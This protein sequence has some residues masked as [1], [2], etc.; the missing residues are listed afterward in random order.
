MGVLEQL[1]EEQKK[2]AVQIG[3]VYRTPQPAIS[4]VLRAPIGM[5]AARPME[6]FGTPAGEKIESALSGIGITPER[7]SKLGYQ[8]GI[9]DDAEIG[10]IPAASA[11]PGRSPD[12]IMEL[13]RKAREIEAG[14]QGYV[15]GG[16]EMPTP[17]TPTPE[18]PSGPLPG[19]RAE[20]TKPGEEPAPDGMSPDTRAMLL[21]L[22]SGLTSAGRRMADVPTLADI[23]YGAGTQRAFTP[24]TQLSG[25][26]ERIETEQ[27][28]KVE[29]EEAK[30]KALEEGKVSP[31]V[32]LAKRYATAM[33]VDPESI[34]TEQQANSFLETAGAGEKIK[35][36]EA[37]RGA[38]EG[39][40]EA[41]AAEAKRA[42]IDMEAVAAGD[43]SK[44][45]QDDKD[46]IT[47][48]KQAWRTLPATKNYKESYA[49]AKQVGALLDAD[50][51]TASRAAIIAIVKA[52][53]ETGRLSD[54]DIK[55]FQNRMGIKGWT[56]RIENTLISDLNP[57]QKAEFKTVVKEMAQLA[58]EE[59]EGSA[60]RDI[61][62]IREM[63]PQYPEAG[64]LK[65][66][67]GYKIGEKEDTV[68]LINVN[69]PSDIMRGVPRDKAEPFLKSKQVRILG[70]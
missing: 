34:K 53:G 57:E 61:T 20:I 4:D 63:Y 10:P 8:L 70:E 38:I 46:R 62:S 43:I 2:K 32:A 11:A 65:Y 69:D 22:M 19:A 7:I 52:S 24:E 54:Q 28:A 41:L 55:N 25:A 15:P 3:D 56:D 35:T 31:K 42:E 48:A 5:S 13:I 33:G 1:L 47:K 17:Q 23:R 6:E 67:L 44:L 39:K 27:R 18:T 29:E 60:K 59:I 36:L 58:I 66:F 14:R 26:A 21:R 50:N 68:D 45:P 64:L 12:D 30:A 51:S 37:Q 40:T 49:A 16:A 9:T